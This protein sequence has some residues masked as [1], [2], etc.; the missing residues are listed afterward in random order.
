M[1][2][3]LE[4]STEYGVYVKCLVCA[5][6]HQSPTHPQHRAFRAAKTSRRLSEIIE[7]L[8]SSSGR[9]STSL[10]N[11]GKLSINAS[12]LSSASCQF[13]SRQNTPSYTL[14]GWS[15]PVSG[16]CSKKSRRIFSTTLLRDLFSRSAF[17][18]T[19]PNISGLRVNPVC[20]LL[21]LIVHIVQHLSTNVNEFIFKKNAF[22][23]LT[24]VAEG[25]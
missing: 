8:W 15:S 1:K 6:L 13:Q 22:R 11:G 14:S 3:P 7:L 25:V 18:T 24:F 16:F 2:V 19:H 23:G 10:V 17:A 20:V 9:F 5:L 12:C 4:K 21:S